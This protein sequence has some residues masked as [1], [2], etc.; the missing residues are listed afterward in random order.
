MNFYSSFLSVPALF[1]VV[2]FLRQLYT[3]EVD[4]PW[5][6]YFMLLMAI[7]STLFLEY[8]KRRNSA[9]AYSWDIFNADEEHL[10]MAGDMLT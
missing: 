10:S 6:P 4:N 9:L 3:G 5:S 7:W 1:G 2:L 8:W